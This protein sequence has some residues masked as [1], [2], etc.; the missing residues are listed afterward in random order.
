[1]KDT[2]L[3]VAAHPDDEL[4]GVAGTLKK[5]VNA[6]NDVYCVIL[7]EGHASRFDKGSNNDILVEELH[8][9]S[10]E[11]AK[12]IGFKENHFENLPDNRFD[13]LDLL[14]VIKIVEKHIQNIKPNIL[15]THHYGDRN[16][17]HRITYDAVMTAVRPVGKYC[18]NKVYLFDTPSS[19]EW[20]FSGQSSVFVPNTFVNIDDTI[21]DK[22]K[23]MECYK[24]ELGIWP[25]PRSSKALLAIANRY[26]SVIG[27]EY[28][29]AFNLI[30]SIEK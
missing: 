15:Y 20:S 9:D 22:I 28:A 2:I 12:M 3:V 7:G 25:H 4:L 30:M 1:M 8:K 23:A 17:D 19:T 13:S 29:E 21:D 6:G 14:D 18:V 16:I 10:I 26:G 24:T 11:S 5:H 27:C